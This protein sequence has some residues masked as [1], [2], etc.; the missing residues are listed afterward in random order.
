ML[1]MMDQAAAAWQAAANLN[2]F[3][4]PATQFWMAEYRAQRGNLL[5]MASQGAADMMRKDLAESWNPAYDSIRRDFIA[6]LKED[7]RDHGW[8]ESLLRRSSD[9]FRLEFTKKD[10]SEIRKLKIHLELVHSTGDQLLNWES[11]RTLFEL[12]GIEAPEKAPAAGAVL[13]DKTGLFR[14][15]IVD[16]DHYYPLKKRDDLARRLDP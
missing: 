12:L 14:A 4:G 13:T 16:G 10:V 15:T 2:P 3:L 5:A 7:A 6:A 8:Q 9:M 11:A 1:N